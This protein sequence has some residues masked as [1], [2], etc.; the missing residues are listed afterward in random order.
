MYNH[1]R[2]NRNHWASPEMGQGL[3]F[4]RPNPWSR[5]C[6]NSFQTALSPNTEKQLIINVTLA[7]ETTRNKLLDVLSKRFQVPVPVAW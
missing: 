7:N 5:A 2:N 1:N 4:V 6:F 3:R